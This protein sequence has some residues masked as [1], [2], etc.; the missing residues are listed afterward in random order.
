MA[1]GTKISWSDAT[2]N[3]ITGCSI[4]SPGCTHCYAMHLAGTRL[5]DHPSRAGLTYEVN[6][7]HVWTGEVRFNDGTNGTPDWLTQ[8]LRWTKP[9]MIFVC[10]HGDLFHENVP[11]E[12]LDKVFAVMAL[13][14]QHL[15][16]VLTKRS[17]RMWRYMNHPLTPKRI[18]YAILNP[19]ADWGISAK[20]ALAALEIRER[21][22]EREADQF[23]V[24]WPLP[25]VWAG[26]SAEDQRRWDERVPRLRDTPAA[27]RWV[28]AEPL[29]GPIMALDDVAALDWIVVGGESGRQARF[30]EIEWARTLRNMA[31]HGETAFFMKQL[32]AV[33]GRKVEDIDQFPEDLRVREYPL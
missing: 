22:S 11:D 3:V 28:S 1:D 4:A 23:S 31:W 30:M 9:R 27:V 13:A 18:A 32:A 7:N 8:P 14:P 5:R 33:N 16:Q 10:A 26:V 19:C 25:N 29:I 21:E 20:D 17:G 15:F 2:W 6:G 12:W 24:R